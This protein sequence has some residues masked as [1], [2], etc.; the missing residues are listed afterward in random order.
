MQ[1]CILQDLNLQIAK[2]RVVDSI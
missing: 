1:L 2:L